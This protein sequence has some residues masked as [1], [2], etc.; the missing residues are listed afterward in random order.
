MTFCFKLK[1]VLSLSFTAWISSFASETINVCESLSML[2]SISIKTGSSTL[3]QH[4]LT[5]IT[6]DQA[7]LG[8]TWPLN[9]NTCCRH[10]AMLKINT[11]SWVDVSFQVVC[12]IWQLIQECGGLVVAGEPGGPIIA[13]QGSGPVLPL[14][15]GHLITFHHQP[16]LWDP[17]L[18]FCTCW[19]LLDLHQTTNF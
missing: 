4:L 5:W 7:C 8:S 1:L 11:L 6:Y 16:R 2:W 17:S 14:S 19:H 18:F 15:P 13:E 12:H 3:S 10:F 9:M